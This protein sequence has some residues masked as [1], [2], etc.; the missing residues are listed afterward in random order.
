[1]N[2]IGEISLQCRWN[3]D[4]KVFVTTSKEFPELRIVTGTQQAAHDQVTEFI[5]QQFNPDS[6]KCL[7]MVTGSQDELGELIEMELAL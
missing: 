3:A 2:K 5:E 1:M 6:D 4:S 7:E